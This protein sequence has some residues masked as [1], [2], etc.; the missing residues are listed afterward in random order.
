MGLLTI[1]IFF[2]VSLPWLISY[3]FMRRSL[4]KSKTLVS[5]SVMIR[6]LERTTC[7]RNSVTLAVQML[8]RACTRIWLPGIVLASARFTY[9]H[10]SKN[11]IIMSSA[12]TPPT[13]R[14]SEW[15]R[16]RRQTI[17]A[18]LTSNNSL[19]LTWSSPSLIVS[20]NIVRNLLPTALPHFKGRLSTLSGMELNLDNAS[21]FTMCIW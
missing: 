8:S 16:S 19:L 18:V 21:L 3:R 13:R 14:F 12:Y 9:A 11:I 17:F 1:M 2:C 4:W 10:F 15:L 7:T 6:G 20:P 5:G